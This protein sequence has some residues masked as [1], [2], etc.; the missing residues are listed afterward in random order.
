MKIEQVSRKQAEIDFATYLLDPDFFILQKAASDLS[1]SILRIKKQKM[2]NPHRTIQLFTTTDGYQDN[3][4]SLQQ[5]D[6][7][8]TTSPV[9][10]ISI[11]SVLSSALLSKG[12][13]PDAWHFY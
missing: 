9:K 11:F 6:S 3:T 4:F 8:V 2:G 10:A 1:P 7:P 5:I 12:Y 13:W